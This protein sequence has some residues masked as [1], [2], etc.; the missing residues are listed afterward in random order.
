MRGYLEFMMTTCFP[1]VASKL[2]LNDSPALIFV[3]IVNTLET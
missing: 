3:L 1:C 2:K